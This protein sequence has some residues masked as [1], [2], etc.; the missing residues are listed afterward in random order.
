MREGVQG[1][2]EVKEEEMRT[3]LELSEGWLDEASE[4]GRELWFLAQ[5][6]K[7]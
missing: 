1:L 5:R 4:R 7:P 3:N 6:I 2:I